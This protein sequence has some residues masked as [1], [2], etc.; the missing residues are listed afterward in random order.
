MTIAPLLSAEETHKPV[1]CDC[2]SDCDDGAVMPATVDPGVPGN[3]HQLDT[4]NLEQA[5][6]KPRWLRTI[7][8]C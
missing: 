5:S 8:K 3:K 4:F 6:I 1:S 7:T 2:D